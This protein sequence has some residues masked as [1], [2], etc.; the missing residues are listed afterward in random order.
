MLLPQLPKHKAALI[1]ALLDNPPPKS[2]QLIYLIKKQK[3]KKP[4]NRLIMSLLL[5][6]LHRPCLTGNSLSALPHNQ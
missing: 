1:A 2:Y 5:P 4:S 3:H 6:N